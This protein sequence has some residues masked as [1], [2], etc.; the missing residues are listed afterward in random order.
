MDGGWVG[1]PWTEKKNKK[2]RKQ[3]NDFLKTHKLEVTA[4]VVAAV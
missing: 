4:A 3:K 1:N 2:K